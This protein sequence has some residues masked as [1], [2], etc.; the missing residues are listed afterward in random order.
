M[1]PIAYVFRSLTWHGSPFSSKSTKKLSDYDLD[2]DAFHR[3][4]CTLMPYAGLGF[5]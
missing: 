3:F 5:C 4:T 1:A 2:V